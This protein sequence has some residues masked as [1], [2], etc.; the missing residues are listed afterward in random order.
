[1]MVATKQLNRPT[2]VRE[3]RAGPGIESD[4]RRGRPVSGEDEDSNHQNDETGK[5]GIQ[6]QGVVEAPSGILSEHRPLQISAALI[7]FQTV[8]ALEIWVNIGPGALR[9]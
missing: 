3:V 6:R 7:A 4:F 5:T 9:M 1:M 8:G 2:L